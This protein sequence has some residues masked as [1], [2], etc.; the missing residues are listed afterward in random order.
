[1][2][3]GGRGGWGEDCPFSQSPWLGYVGGV[4]V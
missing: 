1:M 2:G 3:H 4:G